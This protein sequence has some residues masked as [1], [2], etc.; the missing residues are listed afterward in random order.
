MRT[1]TVTG[2]GSVSAVPDTAVVRVSAVHRAPA[3]ADALAGVSST[4][5]A[6]VAVARGLVAASDVG[7]EDLSV[8][9]AQDDE[10]RPDGFEARHGY[11]VACDS[12]DVA[13]TLVAELAQQ[14][15]DRLRVEGVALEL[16]DRA[17]AEVAAREAAYD[18]ARARA[19]HLA[20][21]A[22]V[23]LGDVQAVVEGGGGG[24]L[25]SS[26]AGGGAYASKLSMSFEP[27]HTSVRQA[28]TVTWSVL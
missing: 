3:L 2:H 21:L 22:G 24:V 14:V 5:D 19:E 17:T 26:D 9:P 15:G 11:R 8:W 18:D 4:G 16:S 6:I 13:G 23:A 28:L 1:L 12:L 27:G 7:S 10:G 20:G 25:S